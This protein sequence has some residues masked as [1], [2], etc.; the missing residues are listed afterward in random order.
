MVAVLNRAHEMIET[1][2]G[3][4]VRLEVNYGSK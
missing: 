1:D 4:S 2:K 3:V